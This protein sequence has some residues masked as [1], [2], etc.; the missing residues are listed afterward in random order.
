MLEDTIT[1]LL[2]HAVRYRRYILAAFLVGLVLQLTAQHDLTHL[3][4]DYVASVYNLKV[5]ESPQIVNE[6]CESISDRASLLPE[7]QYLDIEELTKDVQLEGWEDQWLDHGHLP[8]GL[9][10]RASKF[11]VVYTHVD[12][13]TDYLK[14][15][16]EYLHP[17]DTEYE[18][19][20]GKLWDELKYSIRGTMAHAS[21]WVSAIHLV[22]KSYVSNGKRITQVPEWLDAKD[23][24]LRITPETE[25]S[26]CVTFNSITIEST[27]TKL[28][29]TKPHFIA[30][31]DDM[32]FGREVVASDFHSSLFGMTMQQY[33]GEWWAIDQ[34]RVPEL[35]GADG[36]L[37]PTLFTSY[38]L[39][40]RFGR[41][42]RHLQQHFPKVVNQEIMA[43]SLRTFP[44][45]ALLSTASTV[46]GDRLQVYPWYLHMWYT[47]ESH[48]Q[49]LIWS[50]VLRYDVDADN[51]IDERE[52]ERFLEDLERGKSMRCR[53]RIGNPILRTMQ[54]TLDRTNLGRMKSQVAYWSSLDGPESLSW[55]SSDTCNYIFDNEV[56]LPQSQDKM[57]SKEFFDALMA[58]PAICGDCVIKRLLDQTSAGLAPLLP[59]NANREKAVKAIHKYQ[60]VLTNPDS[61][62]LRVAT[63]DS[64]KQ[65]FQEYL[66]NL[67]AFVCINDDVSSST[68]EEVLAIADQYRAL[69][70]SN[71]PDASKYELPT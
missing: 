65:Q 54:E 52:H 27:L 17:L 1:R 48:R 13:N 10:P 16:H 39:G 51:M 9:Q 26:P 32:L 38:L 29:L 23:P 28:N 31:S 53:D 60:Y 70:E 49:A 24:T 68:D 33:Q 18:P 66:G 37:T 46:R 11:D 4:Q 35:D 6:T 2:S 43:E 21:S 45:A 42:V 5:S 20:Q 56:C 44:N 36:E 50:I 3:S 7:I 47:I 57:S 61:V 63:L 64:A 62:F 34:D 67:P 41:R 58:A 71:F 40:K 15:K 55:V 8:D 12:E 69:Y 19:K 25:I 22:T 14:Y 59:K 30:M